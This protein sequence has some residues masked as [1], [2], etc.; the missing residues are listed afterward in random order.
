MSTAV[1]IDLVVGEPLSG[2]DAPVRPISLAEAAAVAALAQRAGVA[3][4][5]LVDGTPGVR[6]ID[7]SVVGAFLAGRYGDIGYL[8][9]VPTTAGRPG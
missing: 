3:A 5:R 4:L 8:V 6:T 1:L 2:S 9:D 7:P